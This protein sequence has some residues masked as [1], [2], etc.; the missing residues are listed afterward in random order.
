MTT[1]QA[2]SSTSQGEPRR[3]GT[4]CACGATRELRPFG[5]YGMI[6]P[7][8]DRKRGTHTQGVRP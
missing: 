2:S 4:R 5:P 3:R 7:P 6:C 8:C 1:T